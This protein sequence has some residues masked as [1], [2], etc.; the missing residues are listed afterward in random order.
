MINKVFI[1]LYKILVIFAM[2]V[3]KCLLFVILFF[4]LSC[5]TT[6]KPFTDISVLNQNSQTDAS[7]RG[8]FVLNENTIWASGTNGTVLVS[9]DSGESWKLIQVPGAE[10]NDFR[11]IHAWD[12]NGALVFG[13]AGP[14]FGYLTEDGGNSWNVVYSDTTKGVFFDSLKF[15]DSK[16]GLAVS[17][18]TVGKPFVIKT[19][20]GGNSWRKIENLPA[21]LDGEA[22]FAAS[23]TC[24]E[25]L[26]S[27]KA[28]IITGGSAARVFY[29]GDFGEKWKVAETPIIDE[30]ASSGIFSVSFKNNFEGVIAG[31]TFDKPALN[32]NI[33]AFTKDGGETWISSEIM[34]KEYRSCVQIVSFGK[35][36][37]FFVIGKTGCD[38]S[39]DNGKT[40]NFCEELNYYTFRQVPGKNFGFA[41]GSEGRIAKLEFMI[42]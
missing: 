21:L 17:D 6:N 18:Q 14:D 38:I 19:T 25:F 27:G 4:L 34:P 22:H 29:S 1:T 42:Q 35:K 13:I 11:S 33:A 31:G 39:S 32:E 7:I 12:K 40:W 2:N 36:N 41:A 30:N 5:K 9:E 16:I 28:W 23:N 20:D 26:P 10:E 37:F 8:L 24:V 3:K 15:A